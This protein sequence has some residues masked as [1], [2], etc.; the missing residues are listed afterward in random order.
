MLRILLVLGLFLMLWWY[1]YKF[2][3]KRFV[4]MRTELEDDEDEPCEYRLHEIKDKQNK[5]KADCIEAQKAAA[6]KIKEAEKIRKNL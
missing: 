6:R 2:L 4:N 1:V 3:L 5:L